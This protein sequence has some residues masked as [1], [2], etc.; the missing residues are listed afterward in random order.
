VPIE[1]HGDEVTGNYFDLLGARPAI[2]RFFHEADE[3]GPN[4]A[5]YVVLS[6]A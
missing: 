6:D 3:H 2:G 1:V 5:P 4:S